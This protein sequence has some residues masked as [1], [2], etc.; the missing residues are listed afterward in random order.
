MTRVQD[1]LG[2]SQDYTSYPLSATESNVGTIKE[3]IDSES[4]IIE[5]ESSGAGYSTVLFHVDQVF[6]LNTER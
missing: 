6:N 2:A 1:R 4:G 3:Y 5:I